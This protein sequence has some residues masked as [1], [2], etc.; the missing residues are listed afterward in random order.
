MSKHFT[1]AD[2]FRETLLKQ[3]LFN[4]KFVII[5]NYLNWKQLAKDLSTVNFSLRNVI[6]ENDGI[7]NKANKCAVIG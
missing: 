1:I 2:K 5:P 6:S 3:Y 7:R 4:I